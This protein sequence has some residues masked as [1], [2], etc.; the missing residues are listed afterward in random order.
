MKRLVSVIA[1]ACFLNAGAQTKN[2]IDQP[3]IEVTAWADSLATPNQIFIRITLS[4][5]DSKDKTA[6]EQMETK[7]VG[8]LRSLGIKTE[9]DLTASDILSNYQY[10]LL[11]KKDIIKTKQY[12]LKVT[13]AYTATKVFIGLEDLDISNVVVDHVD[14]TQLDEIKN[15]C[16]VKAIM[17]AKTKA[18]SITR[19]IGQFIGNAIHIADNETQLMSGPLSGKVAGLTVTN[20]GARLQDKYEDLKV[21]FEKIKVSSS[22][23]VKFMLK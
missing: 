18:V 12:M 19:T 8:F 5:K 6:I 16:R 23:S 22:V 11:R 17:N 10:Y 21:D 4:E 9:T 2:F 20:Y 15:I 7:M 1:A 3:F 14:H 13:D